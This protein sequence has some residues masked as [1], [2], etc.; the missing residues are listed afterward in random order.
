LNCVVHRP[1]SAGV[2]HPVSD[3]ILNLQ[4]CVT[5]PNKNDQ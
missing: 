4:N 3:Q 1:Y 2:L 5:N